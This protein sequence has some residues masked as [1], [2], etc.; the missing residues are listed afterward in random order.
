VLSDAFACVLFLAEADHH[1][2]GVG[3]DLGEPGH[4]HEVGFTVH[5]RAYEDYGHGVCGCSGV[6]ADFRHGEFDEGETVASLKYIDSAGGV[7]DIVGGTGG[8]HPYVI[9]L[10]F[11]MEKTLTLLESGFEYV[12]D[13]EGWKVLGRGN[14]AFFPSCDYQALSNV[15]V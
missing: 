3:V 12:L 14:S 1:H 8:I 10:Q 5:R 7:G 15:L 13:Y 6:E 9:I 2:G 11:S 4:R